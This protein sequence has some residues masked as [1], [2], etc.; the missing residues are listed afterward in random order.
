MQDEIAEKYTELLTVVI[1]RLGKIWEAGEGN[2][3]IEVRDDNNTK[4]AKV[5]GGETDR[6]K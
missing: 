1:R 6:I 2:L 4:K 3:T 5:M